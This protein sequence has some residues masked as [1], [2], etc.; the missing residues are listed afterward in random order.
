MMR[1]T[2]FLSVLAALAVTTLLAQ[3]SSEIA[4]RQSELQK[5]RS[6]IESYEK[7]LSESEKKEKLTLE[8]IDNLERQTTLLKGLI[9][10]LK[11]EERQIT[12]D[13][14]AARGSIMDLE[15]QLQALRQHYAGYVRSVYKHGRVYDVELLFSSRSIN[16]LYIRIEYLK[17][18]SD[19]RAKD[20][21]RIVE[22]KGD[23][24]D[25]NNRLVK[26][27]DRERRLLAEKTKE[28]QALKR[29][30]ADRQKALKQIRRDR[31]SYVQELNRRRAAA[32]EMEKTI[33]ELIERD[34]LKKE[35][36]AAEARERERMG[37][38]PAVVPEPTGMFGQKRGSLRWPVP[39]GKIASR[40]GN[41]VHPVLKTVTENTGIDIAV[42]VGTEVMAVAPGEVSVIKFI[43]GYG[44]V[45]ILNHYDG[46]RTVYGY[47]SDIFVTETQ[48][49]QEGQIIARSGESISGSLLHF[50][51][52]KDRE[53]HNPE[54]WLI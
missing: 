15:S 20:L 14:V 54:T 2:P 40:F 7:K 16:Q 24:E 51:I 36:E 10:K 45:M 9:R 21:R 32:K 46:Y 3:S 18:F 44:N 22:K 30:S 34:R 48:R 38:G 26:D 25:Q 53:K 6:E 31:N 27:L 23:L 52:W 4:R 39:S 37:M 33:A 42:G 13:I 28:E 41:H 47:L 29:R 43:P 11:E 5:L 1:R 17:R 49:V 8:R 12:A 35:R 19:Q 50:E